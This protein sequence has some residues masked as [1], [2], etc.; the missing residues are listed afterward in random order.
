MADREWLPFTAE[1]QR[2]ITE[3]RKT[4]TSRPRKYGEKGDVVDS[5]VGPLRLTS[6]TK[7]SLWEVAHDHWR[8]EGA[9]SPEDF[10]RIW[11]GIHREAGWRDTWSIHFHRFERVADA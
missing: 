9:E 4:A 10:K 5:P 6:V 11:C 2:A 8:E 7:M 3:G 1:M